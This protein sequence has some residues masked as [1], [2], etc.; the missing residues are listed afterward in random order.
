MKFE[1]K[2]PL[3]QRIFR[4]LK[5]KADLTRL[6]GVTKPTT[7]KILEDE[8]K[9]WPFKEKICDLIKVDHRELGDLIY[10]AP[11]DSKSKCAE[12]K[13]LLVEIGEELLNYR[14]TR[15]LSRNE[16]YILRVLEDKG[17]V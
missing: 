15:E 14:K 11:K 5:S 10:G 1:P 16:M 9:F 4:K 17:T 2:S 12:Y 6:L 13:R 7:D 3:Q 8:T